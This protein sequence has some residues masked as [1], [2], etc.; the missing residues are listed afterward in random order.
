MQGRNR[1]A[2]W[3]LVYPP[4]VVA[5][6]VVVGCSAGGSSKSS[7]IDP[8]AAAAYAIEHYDAND[9][10]TI[11]PS[12]LSKCPALAAALSTFDTGGDGRL[13]AN[14]I[15]AGLNQMYSSERLTEMTCRVT[16]QGRPLAGAKVRLTPI[17]ML[18][19]ALMPAEGVTNQ[20]G[21]A[22]PSITAELLPNEFRHKPLMYP[23]L[24]DVVITHPQTQLP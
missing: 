24:Y 5:L 9:D 11:A 8:Q 12:E 4:S 1:T 2:A 20:R 6:L 21:I 3:R 13:V 19:D 16:L 22:N 14:E 23:G 15:V 17:E 18:G 7:D 10:G